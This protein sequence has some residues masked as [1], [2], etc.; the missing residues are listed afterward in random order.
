MCSLLN[1]GFVN[2]F[3]YMCVLYC[4]VPFGKTVLSYCYANKSLESWIYG[5]K[6]NIHLLCRFSELNSPWCQP[7]LT[8]CVQSW[9]HCP[10]HRSHEDPSFDGH[11][12][13]IS[14]SSTWVGQSWHIRSHLGRDLQES[15]SEPSPEATNH[16]VHYMWTLEFTLGEIFKKVGASPALKRQIIPFIICGLWNALAFLTHCK[17]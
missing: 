1:N 5:T 2:V 10:T 13:P 7:S 14:P 17:L 12:P 8:L 15:G 4:F 3:L 6:A 16:T 11:A 9:R